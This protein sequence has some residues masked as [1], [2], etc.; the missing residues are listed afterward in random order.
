[1]IILQTLAVA[2]SMFSAVPMPRFEWTERNMRYM[3]CA[4]PLVGCAIGL[5]CWAW[6][7]VCAALAL[8]SILCGAGLCLIPA[9]FT[10]GIHL[11]GFADT[12]DALSSRAQPQRMQE[13]LKDPH[14][15]AFAAIRLCMYFLADF[16]LWT[17]LPRFSPACVIG[18]FC[19]SRS[20]SGLAVSSFPLAK[21]TGLA[22]TF[23][24]AADRERVRLILAV[25]SA[26][27]AVTLIFCGGW[28]A[29]TAAALLFVWFRRLCRVRFGG[30]SGDLS[31]WFVQTSELAMLAAL[32]L[33]QF[34][35]LWW[36]TL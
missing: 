9:A 1:M 11:D 7:G 5:L 31:G 4:L 19:F 24:A 33:T 2:F 8:P 22:H 25:F 16:A 6:H 29:A 12:C 35:V 10:G 28:L 32:A 13:I 34:I 14:I 23:A 17:S 26:A 20:L 21:D 27:L 36:H 3:L 30:L 15:G 18:L